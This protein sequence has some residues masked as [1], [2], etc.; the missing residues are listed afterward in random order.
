MSRRRGSYKREALIDE[1][2]AA[3][4]VAPSY[5]SFQCYAPVG[6]GEEIVV[7]GDTLAR[8][9]ESKRAEEELWRGG[10]RLVSGVRGVVLYRCWGGTIP[11]S[12][13]S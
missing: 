10:P 11:S 4:P 3:A 5:I 6:F 9:P 13:S 7:T 8:S 1:S 12:A 2:R